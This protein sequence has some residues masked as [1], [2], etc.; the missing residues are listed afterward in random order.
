MTRLNAAQLRMA[1]VDPK[2]VIYT[3]VKFK[4]E[5]NRV[6]KLF[7]F[8]FCFPYISLH[9]ES[10]LFFCQMTKVALHRDALLQVNLLDSSEF[11]IMITI[12]YRHKNWNTKKYSSQSTSRIESTK[13]TGFSCELINK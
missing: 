10:S 13:T 8:S 3:N 12:I 11:I 1:L 6:R 9:H 7:L 2:G 4:S 5:R